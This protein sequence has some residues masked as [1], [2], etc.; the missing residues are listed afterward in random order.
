[1]IMSMM[2]LEELEESLQEILPK[3]FQIDTDS[4]GQ[5][6]IYTGLTETDDGDLIEFESDDD[7]DDDDY[8]VDYDSELSSLDEDEDEDD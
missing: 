1:M 4:N 3:G 6:V 7:D 8:H 2:T 5:I